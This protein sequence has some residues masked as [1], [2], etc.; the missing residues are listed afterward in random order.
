MPSSQLDAFQ[1]AAAVRERLVELGLESNFVRDERLREIC[2]AIWEGSPT[3]GGLVSDIW[4]EA[5]FPAKSSGVTLAQLAEEGVFH[6]GLCDHLDARGAVPAERQLY[7][8]QAAAIRS[9]AASS[10]GARPGLVITAGTGAGKTESF[11]LP[12]LNELFSG[13]SAPQGGGARCL[14]V[15]PMNALVND[16]VERLYGWLQGQSDVTVFHFTSETPEDARTA[17]RRGLPRW[18]PCRIRTRNEARGLEDHAGTRIDL[19]RQPRGRVPD[20]V[21]TNY[22]MLEYMLCRPQDAVFFGPALSTVILDEAHLYTGTLAA[23]ITLL[24]R[25]LRDRCERSPS[26]VTCIAT[27]ATIG[28]G[29]RGE[30]ESF[31]SAIFSKDRDAMTVI[32]GG[33]A[34]VALGSESPPAGECSAATVT[35]RDWLTGPTL[36]LPADGEPALSR[37]EELCASL[38][39]DLALLVDEAVIGKA[40]AESQGH[41]ARLLSAAL[42]R[43]PKTHVLENI[44]WRRQR[45]PLAELA[46]ELWGARDDAAIQATVVLL[47]LAAAAK[48]SVDDHPLVPH[49]V[50]F[51][52]QSPVGLSVC[53]DTACG[54][55]DPRKLDPFGIVSAGIQDVCPRCGAAAVTLARCNN[56]GEWGLVG[57]LDDSAGTLRPASFRTQGKRFFSARRGATGPVLT[58]DPRSGRYGGSGVHSVSITGVDHCPNC[59]ADAATEWGTFGAPDALAVSIL[60]ETL[61]ARVPEYAAER[62]RWLPARGRRLL[63]F[64]DSRQEAARLGPRLTRQHEYQVLRAAMTE[65]L[66]KAPAADAELVGYYKEEIERI[67]GELARQDLPDTVRRAH[68]K[69]LEELRDLLRQAE[70]GGSIRDWTALLSQSALIAEMLDAEHATNDTKRDWSQRTQRA[71]EANRRGVEDGLQVMLGR[72][73][74]R[75][76]R[77]Q[78]SLETLGLIEVTYPGLD[79]ALPPGGLLGELPTAAVRDGLSEHW[80]EYLSLLCDSLRTDGAITLGTDEDDA[81][82]GERGPRVGRWCAETARGVRWLVSFVGAQPEQRRRWMTAR[83]LS[84]LGVPESVLATMTPSLLGWAFRQLRDMAAQFS[85]ITSVDQDAGGRPVAA[86]RLVFPELGL[87]QPARL[88]R[89]ERTDFI[90]THSV[91]GVAPHLGCDALRPITGPELDK[92]P[93][94]GRLRREL[95][96]SEVFKLAVW[97]EEH[98]AQLAPGENRRL[99]DLFKLGARNVLSSTTTLELGIDIGGLNAVLMSNVPPNKANYLQRAGRAGRRSD[100]ASVAVAYARQRPFD[101]EVFARFGDYL[102]RTLQRPRVLLD[103]DRVVRRH[104]HAFVLGEFFRCVYPPTAHVGAM[105]A[106]GHMGTFAGV[107]LPS[108]WDGAARPAVNRTPAAQGQ[109]SQQPWH[110][111]ARTEPGLEG[112]FLDFLFWL[113]DYGLRGYRDRVDRILESTGVSRDEW[114]WSGLIDLI[115]DDFGAAVARWREDYESLLLAWYSVDTNAPGHRRVANSIRYQLR[116]LYDTTVIESL[117]DQQFLPH[118]GFP[119]GLQGLRVIVPDP[120]SNRGRVRTE[121]QFR[122]ERSG[123]LALGEYVPGSQLLVGGKVVTSRGLLKHWTGA[124]LDNYLGLRGQ[125]AECD[126]GHLYY[127]ISKPLRRCPVCGAD[128]AHAPHDLLFARHGYSSAA[129]D[130]PKRSFDYDRVGTIEQATVTFTEEP[131]EGSGSADDEGFAGVS[132]LHASYREDGELLVYNKGAAQCGFAI[133]LRCGYAESERAS[134]S[135]RAN[136]PRGFDTHAPLDAV[137]EHSRCWTADEDAP[138]LRNQTLAAREPTDVLLIDFSGPLGGRT[139]DEDLMLTLASALLL[140]GA[141]LLDLDSRELGALLTPAGPSGQAHGVVLYDGVAGG[142]G[143]VRELLE[144]GQELIQRTI[145]LLWVSEEHDA[146]CISGCLDCLMTFDRQMAAR[147]PFR[148]REALV[149]LRGLLDPSHPAPAQTD[150]STGAAPLQPNDPSEPKTGTPSDTS[151]E[152]VADQSSEEHVLTTDER[153]Q[154]ARR[155]RTGAEQD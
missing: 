101:R 148:R 43:A 3:D 10:P 57:L 129:W 62:R 61:L 138:V 136:L 118:Y 122:L 125:Y 85:W 13:D 104:V 134:G 47:Q 153:V 71:W 12:I 140:A 32:E 50:H 68:D 6:R 86:I 82:Y 114:R 90:W 58:V 77:A 76:A 109:I 81:E 96:E 102:G 88:Y 83:V 18:D 75:P 34:R 150:D 24:L 27:S 4:V 38:A 144:R 51:L 89:C 147:R 111:P 5:T 8:H 45:L 116:A 151:G 145:D 40:L 59:A 21:I 113:R 131:R 30:L 119:I 149:A 25:R 41:P 92:D 17:D 84:S 91:L 33:R 54:N 1:T 42:R 152:S 108:K 31:G 73:L 26:D 98:S 110:N 52:G 115:I 49:R 64:S 15:Y 123:M 97:A 16:Q 78:T 99:Q 44:L 35:D 142:A 133:C 72:E 130:P 120:N 29:Q 66:A 20:I 94:I 127:S 2:R 135:G 87:R 70:V 146:R 53:L 107:P 28:T 139:Q 112:H 23:E 126:N 95:A 117:A 105:D 48:T 154:R 22:S 7:D 74:A 11:L 155:R 128:A 63:A 19:G 39:R 65:T 124:N 121:D 67:R 60:A 36:E 93:R 55:G 143:H 137:N 106:F 80:S 132:G 79:G 56:C 14:I 103:R 9:C 100:G 69:R 37:S 141:N 46:Q